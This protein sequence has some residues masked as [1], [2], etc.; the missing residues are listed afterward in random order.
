[1]HGGLAFSAFI[2]RHVIVEELGEQNALVALD[3][4][5]HSS[6]RTAISQTI[7]DSAFSV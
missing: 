5:L 3:K 4:E 2:F 1:M 7:A 6:P